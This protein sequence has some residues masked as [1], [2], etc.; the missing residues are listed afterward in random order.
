MHT[1]RQKLAPAPHTGLYS[2]LVPLNSLNYPHVCYT[3]CSMLTVLYVVCYQSVNISGIVYNREFIIQ[4]IPHTLYKYNYTTYTIQVQIYHIHYTSTNIPHTLYKYMT[5]IKHN[6]FVH[7]LV[8]ENVSVYCI[9]ICK[10]HA[11]V[12]TT[13]IT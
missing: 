2:L 9:S 7:T 3:Q 6:L 12:E 8:V 10:I 5:H 13:Y 4:N 1:I 11:R